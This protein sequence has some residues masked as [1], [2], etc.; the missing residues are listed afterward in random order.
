MALTLAMARALAAC[1]SWMTATLG[2]PAHSNS[3]ASRKLRAL[4]EPQPPNPVIATVAPSV[5]RCQSSGSGGTDTLDFS[6]GTAPL[7]P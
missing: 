4:H 7:M 5:R 6:T 3:T 2:T 1:D